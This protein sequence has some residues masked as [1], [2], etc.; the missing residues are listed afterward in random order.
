[1]TPR[2]SLVAALVL[3]AVVALVAAGCTGGDGPRPETSASDGGTSAA[4]AT[5]ADDGGP[6]DGGGAGDDGGA[7]DGEG[8]DGGSGDGGGSGADDGSGDDTPAPTSAPPFVADTRPDQAEP[9]GAGGTLLTVT[10]IRTG[11]H[12][13]FDRV[14]FDLGGTGPGAPGWDV[15]YVPEALD[16]GSGH[17]VEVAG[18]AILQVR[19]S[20]TAA[21]TDSGVPGADRTPIRPADT[22][23]V[24]EVLYRTWFEGYSTAFVGIDDGERPFRVFLLTD[25]VR[26]VLDVQH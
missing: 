10:D 13:G 8:S 4:S 18:D 25:P 22:E 6:G 5:P 21:P 2:R 20:G 14:V 15:R 1:M 7:D 9:T 12:P 11:V 24:E 19:I 3:P 17:R 16:D 26:V 23:A